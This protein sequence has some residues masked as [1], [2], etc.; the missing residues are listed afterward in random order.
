M[1]LAQS[2]ITFDGL[3]DNFV[4]HYGGQLQSIQANTFANSLV[5]VARII[6]EINYHLHPDCKV[7]I[8][9]ET[10]APG[11]FR[12]KIKIISGSLVSKIKSFLPA[13][14]QTIQVLLALFAL[15]PSLFSSPQNITINHNE[16][17]IVNNGNQLILP[18]EIYDHAKNIGTN[19]KEVQK[20]MTQNFEVLASDSSIESFGA[21]RETDSHE[22]LV[23]IPHQK[24]L[25]YS[26]AIKPQDDAQRIEEYENVEL[27]LLK[28]ILEKG[29][30]KW[31]FVW[32][33][34]RISAP[35][36]DENFWEKMKHKEIQISQGDSITA[37]LRVYQ[38]LE[39]YSSVYLND[40]YEVTEVKN[41]NKSLRQRGD[42]FK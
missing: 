38:V 39:P 12:P 10:L 21:V 29:S 4:I 33:G 18:K 24:F 14:D 30:R 2:T 25:E 26:E 27:R 17:I 7:E 11:S 34:I 5:N 36:L 9:V 22:F 41:Y 6:E 31:D 1:V 3:G 35:I 20:A 32:N 42:L 15:W 28:V 37:K 16:V 23:K 19:N 40:K 13:K 8:R